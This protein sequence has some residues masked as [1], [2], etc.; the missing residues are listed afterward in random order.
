[1]NV[2]FL[3]YDSAAFSH[4]CI[5]QRIKFFFVFHK[6][7]KDVKDTIMK[8]WDISDL[9]VPRLRQRNPVCL[10]DSFRKNVSSSGRFIFNSVQSLKS[11][12]ATC[13]NDKKSSQ[14]KVY[15]SCYMIRSFCRLFKSQGTYAYNIKLLVLVLWWRDV[16]VMFLPIKP[17]VGKIFAG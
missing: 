2:I 4:V 17:L 3:P 8:E 12:T 6:T 5:S 16:S 13:A 15:F 9:R 14:F 7:F 10:F 11:T 1:M